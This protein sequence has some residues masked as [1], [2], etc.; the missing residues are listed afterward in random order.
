MYMGYKA[1]MYNIQD[2]KSICNKNLIIFKMHCLFEIQNFK[3]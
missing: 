2:I 1:C 3:L